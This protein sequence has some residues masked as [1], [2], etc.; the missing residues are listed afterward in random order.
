MKR[1][2]IYEVVTSKTPPFLELDYSTG[3]TSDSLLTALPSPYLIPTYRHT[4]FPSS[5]TDGSALIPELNTRPP[6]TGGA[7]SLACRNATIT[8]PLR[9][10]YTLVIMTLHLMH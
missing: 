3:R 2:Y 8:L 9:Y 1:K 4:L 7:L 5:H 10:R 6:P